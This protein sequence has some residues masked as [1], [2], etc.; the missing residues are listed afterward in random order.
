MLQLYQPSLSVAQVLSRVPVQMDDL[1][2]RSPD[3]YGGFVTN[4]GC[5]PVKVSGCT[6]RAHY[7][8]NVVRR[9]ALPVAIL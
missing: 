3:R 5:Q 6:K 9:T 4:G 8:A 7:T 1:A 2:H